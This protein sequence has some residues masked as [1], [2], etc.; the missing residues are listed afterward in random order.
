MDNA[1]KGNGVLYTHLMSVRQLDVS[2][3]PAQCEVHDLT[4]P[5]VLS[6]A[7]CELHDSPASSGRR[8]AADK[9]A[10]PWQT[11]A[12]VTYVAEMKQCKGPH[13]IL[14]PKAVLPNWRNEFAKWAPDLEVVFYD[15][16]S[17][18][19]AVIRSEQMANGTFNVILTHYDL[20]I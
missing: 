18:E 6:P 7:Q 8:A 11:V 9:V 17:A 20:V 1:I 19:R 3:A 2:V 13:L 4:H 16:G 5:V 14:A 12:F 10:V 15:G